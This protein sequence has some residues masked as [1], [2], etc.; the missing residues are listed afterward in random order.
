MDCEQCERMER[1]VKRLESVLKTQD[2]GREEDA[3][4]IVA[5]EAL[6][7][8]LAVEF[9][10]HAREGGAVTTAELDGWAERIAQARGG[11]AT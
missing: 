3:Q 1:H 10:R 5:L 6:L 11:Q 2:M 9:R 4:R 8:S 7:D